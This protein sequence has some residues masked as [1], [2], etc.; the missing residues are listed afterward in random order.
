MDS[1]GL[2]ETLRMIMADLQRRGLH[3]FEL[4]ATVPIDQDGVVIILTFW[5]DETDETR[6][7]L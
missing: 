3:L 4:T 5:K 2:T 6:N 7:N 1:S